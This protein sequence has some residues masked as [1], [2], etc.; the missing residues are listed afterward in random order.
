MAAGTYSSIF[1]ATPLLAMWK[2]REPD[3]QRMQRRALRRAGTEVS[4]AAVLT[5]AAQEQVDTGAVAR[6]PR[7]RRKRR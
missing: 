6:P 2:E 7:Q 4:V 3:W 1:V 5:E